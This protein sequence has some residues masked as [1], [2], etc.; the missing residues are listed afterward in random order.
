M[1]KDEAVKDLPEIHFL[2]IT[3]RDGKMKIVDLDEYTKDTEVKELYLEACRNHGNDN[4]RY[5]KVV[6]TK[7][8]TEVDFIL[9]GS[10][11]D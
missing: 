3:Q 7:L 6:G 5:C 8:R 10:T 9:P 2:L 4:V 1:V 11:G